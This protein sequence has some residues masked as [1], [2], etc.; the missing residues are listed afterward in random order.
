MYENPGGHGPSAVVPL[1]HSS[2]AHKG[3]KVIRTILLAY[4]KGYVV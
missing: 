2:D 3:A 4:T 1:P